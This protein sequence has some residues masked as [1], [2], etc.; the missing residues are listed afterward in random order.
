MPPPP[1]FDVAETIAGGDGW[2]NFGK[3]FHEPQKRHSKET[4]S[5]ILKNIRKN[6]ALIVGPEIA[7]CTKPIKFKGHKLRSLLVAANPKVCPPWG[8]WYFVF[9]NAHAFTILR[10]AINEASDHS[11]RNLVFVKPAVGF[12]NLS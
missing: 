6:W 12:G 1:L 5:E 10:K 3:Q 8:S 4:V 9:D 11:T 7:A 2:P